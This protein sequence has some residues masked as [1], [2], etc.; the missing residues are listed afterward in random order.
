MLCIGLSD[1]P[2]QS[3][4]WIPGRW[5]GHEFCFTNSRNSAKAIKKM[6]ATTSLV[7]C[8]QKQ[9]R[10][11]SKSFQLEIIEVPSF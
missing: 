3:Q 8:K 7:P 4:S 1:I 10:V 6:D 11:G 2:L 9:G 5:Q